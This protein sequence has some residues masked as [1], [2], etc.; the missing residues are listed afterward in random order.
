M[1]WWIKLALRKIDVDHNVVAITRN[2]RPNERARQF[3]IRYRDIYVMASLLY[4]ALL[5]G[6][7]AYITVIRLDER[8]PYR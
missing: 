5:S 6:A 4:F 8:E 1:I 3:S 7:I 2:D